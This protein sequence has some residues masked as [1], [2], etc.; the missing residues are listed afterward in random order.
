[1]ERTL[2][3]LGRT[4]AIALVLISS[5]GAAAATEKDARRSEDELA[6][7]RKLWERRRERA[8]AVRYLIKGTT[9]WP[10]DILAA[11]RKKLGDLTSDSIDAPAEDFVRAKRIDFLMDFSTHR[12]RV[13]RQTFPINSDKP[14]AG[15]T[16]LFDGG[17]YQTFMPLEINEKHR[18]AV[19]AGDLLHFELERMSKPT[20][21]FIEHGD[22]PL[23]FAHGMV[24][25]HDPARVS[26]LASAS[27]RPFTRSRLDGCDCL[28]LRTP[29]INGS[30]F[31][32]EF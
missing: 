29:P 14:I 16:D 24:P 10:G 32:S 30:A 3:Q 31:Y 2:M 18:E 1:M 5:V 12:M 6:A 11:A 13:E 19:T 27:I 21:G 22:Y 25:S 17:E 7:V 28:V 15:Q 20:P 9:Y 26:E 4:A 8:D 23:F